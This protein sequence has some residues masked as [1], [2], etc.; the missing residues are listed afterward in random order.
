ME[1][2]DARVLIAVHAVANISIGV[3]LHLWTNMSAETVLR[4]IFPPWFWPVMFCIAGVLALIGLVWSP[5]FAQFA[6]VYAAIVTGVFGLASL[7]AVIGK[8]MLAA[9]PSTVFLLYITVLKLTLSKLVVER[10][11]MLKQVRESTEQGKSALERSGY[12]TT[13]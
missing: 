12:G 1:A 11:V 8:G 10:A 6:F 4:L 5:R 3:S 7:Y 9:I 13:T 2:K